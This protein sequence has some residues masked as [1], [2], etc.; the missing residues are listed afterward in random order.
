[1]LLKRA[2]R[3][4]KMDFLAIMSDLAP[5]ALDKITAI[6]GPDESP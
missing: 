2:R 5:E 6:K 3:L 1:L 4:V